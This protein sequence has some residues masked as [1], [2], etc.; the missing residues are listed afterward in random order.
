MILNCD[1]LFFVCTENSKQKYVN[2]SKTKKQ[3]IIITKN[4]DFSKKMLFNFVLPFSET[5]LPLNHV[6]V[7]V[8]DVDSEKSQSTL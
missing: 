4:F 3:K 5:E 2:K 1:F 7:E 6:V 8:R